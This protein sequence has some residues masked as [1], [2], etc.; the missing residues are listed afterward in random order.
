M[1]E[2]GKK[3]K[4]AK[5]T[6]SDKGEQKEKAAEPSKGPHRGPSAKNMRHKMYGSKE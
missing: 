2:E 6:V 3:K 1:S 5:A 4:W